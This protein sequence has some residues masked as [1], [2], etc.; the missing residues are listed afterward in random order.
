MEMWRSGWPRCEAVRRTIMFTSPSTATQ[1]CARDNACAYVSWSALTLRAQLCALPSTGLSTLPCLM[2]CWWMPKGG[3]FGVPATIA[4]GLP[5]H[6]SSI[7]KRWMRYLPRASCKNGKELDYVRAETLHEAAVACISYFNMECTGFVW[8]NGVVGLCSEM[9]RVGQ[10]A[11]YE[12]T[13]V[14]WREVLANRPQWSVRPTSSG[15]DIHS[16]VVPNCGEFV[17]HKPFPLRSFE[18]SA[19]LCAS[20]PKC[21]VMAF[22]QSNGLALM[23]R[24]LYS[25]DPVSVSD[26]FPFGVSFHT[27]HF[28]TAGE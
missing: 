18:E 3:C 7:A 14:P 17:L 10:S 6:C 2:G 23:C 20:H 15:L 24:G 16:G 27:C 25:L 13:D 22:D 19:S 1:A 4:K 21:V 26:R 8:Q 12:I 5:K 11:G 9:Q 28:I